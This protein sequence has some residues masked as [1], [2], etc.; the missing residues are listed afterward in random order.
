MTPFHSF[1]WLIF[2]CLCTTFPPPHWSI[3]AVQCCVSFCCTKK[4]IRDF[5][6]GPVVKSLPSN[7]RVQALARKLGSH[8]PQSEEAHELQWTTAKTQQIIPKVKQYMYT[9]ILSVLSLPPRPP[10]TS[11]GHHGTPSWA[12]VPYGSPSLALLYIVVYVSK[13]LSQSFSPLLPH[14]RKSILSVCISLPALQVGSSVPLSRFHMYA[15]I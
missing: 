5:P 12:P 6:G 2:Y 11:R 4:W 10:P 9:C 15:L 3:S 1:L 13:L 7:A 14:V 8:V